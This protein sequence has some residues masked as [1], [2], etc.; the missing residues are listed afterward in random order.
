MPAIGILFWGR[1]SCASFISKQSATT[2]KIVFSRILRRSCSRRQIF[3]GRSCA[4][5]LLQAS[6]TE[7]TVPLHTAQRNYAD[8]KIGVTTLR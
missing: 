8:E 2:E 7:V 4:S 3:V 6:V 1:L 5:N